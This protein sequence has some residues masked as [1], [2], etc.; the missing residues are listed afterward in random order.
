MHPFV[1]VLV[2]SLIVMN[3]AGSALSSS[4]NKARLAQQSAVASSLA[5]FSAYADR[6]ARANPNAD[7]VISYAAASL[8]GW[9]Q[10]HSGVVAYSYQGHAYVTY[11]AASAK[12]AYDIAAACPE[13][14]RCLVSN[15]GSLFEPGSFAPTGSLPAGRG[16]PQTNGVVIQP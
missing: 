14:N 11:Q 8:P 10:P 2:L 12:D 5:I 13:G 1:Y 15:S 16:L 7:T 3:L 4:I 6:F 9:F